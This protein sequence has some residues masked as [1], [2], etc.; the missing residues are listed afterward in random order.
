MRERFIPELPSKASTSFQRAI[1]STYEDYPVPPLTELV[2]KNILDKNLIAQAVSFA[3]SPINYIN[4]NPDARHKLLDNLSEAFAVGVALDPGWPFSP[5]DVNR[6]RDN[7]RVTLL[8]SIWLDIEHTR[9]FPVGNP[10]PSL[11]EAVKPENP[12]QLFHQEKPISL[13]E[14]QALPFN[15]NDRSLIFGRYFREYGLFIV[16]QTIEDEDIGEKPKIYFGLSDTTTEIYRKQDMQEEWLI[17][18]RN[19]RIK[20]RNN[21]REINSMQWKYDIN[22]QMHLGPREVSTIDVVIE[23]G[24]HFELKYDRWVYQFSM[25]YMGPEEKAPSYKVPIQP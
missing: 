9:L 23:F 16:K 4:L 25:G 18:K 8:T 13:S 21:T 1:Q 12:W 7:I 14:L 3:Q 11:D 24:E 20:K 6:L 17:K 19:S 5:D 22:G 15:D 10:D 2:A